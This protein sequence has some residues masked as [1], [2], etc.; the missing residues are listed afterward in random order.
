MQKRGRQFAKHQNKAKTKATTIC[1]KKIKLN[2]NQNQS[3][4][5]R[6]PNTVKHCVLYNWMLMN[7][8]F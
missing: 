6:K 2:E 5:Q 3:T 4:K 8:G 7:F 1:E